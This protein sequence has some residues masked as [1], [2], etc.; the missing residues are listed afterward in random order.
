MSPGGRAR[1]AVAGGAPAPELPAPAEPAGSA[2][3][4]GPGDA[5]EE[6]SPPAAAS[7]RTW[8]QRID[9]IRGERSW[10]AWT[11][12]VLSR[13]WLAVLLLTAGL[14]MRIITQL[15]Y[16]P[17]LLYIDSMKYLYNAWEGTDPLGYKV[18]LKVLLFFGDLTTVTTIQHLCGLV[19]AVLIYVLLLRRGANRYLAALAMAPVLLDGYQ[20][21][22][23]QVIMPDVVFE[24]VLVIAFTVFLW[25]ETAT[26]VTVIATGLILGIAVTIREVG[27]I[28][29]VPALL[30]LIVAKREP[31]VDV[32]GKCVAIIVAFIVPIFLYCGAAYEIGG[33]FWLSAKGSDAGRMAKAVD[34]QTIKLPAAVRPMCPTPAEQRESA[35]WLEHSPQS[36]LQDSVPPGQRVALTS[37]FANAVEK[38]Q[39]LR[40]IGSVLSDAIRL[41]SVT[42]PDV[43][44]V[45]PIW[46]WQ[47]QTHYPTFVTGSSATSFDRPG[48]DVTVRPDGTIIVGYQ[49][50]HTSPW[51]FYVLPKKWGGKAKVNHTLASF[52]RSYQ[53]G[54]G[55]TPGP[56]LLALTILGLIGSLLALVRK[57]NSPRGRQLALASGF[58]FACAVG[59]LLVADVYVFSWRYQLMA[60][61]TL[62]PAGVL[63]LAALTDLFRRRRPSGDTPAAVESSAASASASVA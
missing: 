28:A 54:G 33:R 32:F 62:P 38:Q 52:L 25:K 63:G 56:L 16:Q 41:Y 22:A 50:H 51:H 20:L 60:L 13:H 45:T 49:L 40:V 35:D 2:G 17:A 1:A 23:E 34:C 61:I 48:D 47:F 46:R 39:P 5:Q 15:A 57:W 27:L 24:T 19:M 58:F 10:S 26:W 36:P 11:G 29:I 6:A 43:P 55:F 53:L 37:A 42:R 9:G 21:Q 59:L 18:G 30:Y 12:R 31:W 7:R 4:A 44:G 3:A 14:A 8:A